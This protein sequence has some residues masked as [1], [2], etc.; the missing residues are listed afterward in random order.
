MYACRNEHL[1][2]L[3]SYGC[4]KR[5][6]SRMTQSSPRREML[7]TLE[8]AAELVPRPTVSQDPAV[9]QY[10]LKGMLNMM[11]VATR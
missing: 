5:L 2:N 7:E 6:S 8:S 4:Q 3:N 9:L 11:L 10:E 1:M